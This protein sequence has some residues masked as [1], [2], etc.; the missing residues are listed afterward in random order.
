[1]PNTFNTL[2]N[3]S[4]SFF[5]NMPPAG[6]LQIVVLHIG[7]YQRKKRKLLNMMNYCL[8]SD[9]DMYFMPS[10]LGRMSFNGRLLCIVLISTF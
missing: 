2:L 1:M 3:Y 10:S 9:Y 7:T 8:A 6:A 5:W 4:S